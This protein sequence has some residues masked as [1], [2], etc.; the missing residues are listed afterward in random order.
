MRLAPFPQLAPAAPSA[1]RRRGWRSPDLP[2]LRLYGASQEAP[3]AGRFA[4]VLR[5]RWQPSIPHTPVN[6]G[7]VS[8]PGY[9]GSQVTYGLNMVTRMGSWPTADTTSFIRQHGVEDII[10]FHAWH[11]IARQSVGLGPDGYIRAPD[12]T[13]D[14]RKSGRGHSDAH[15]NERRSQERTLNSGDPEEQSRMEA[16]ALAGMR[17]LLK[18]EVERT[19]GHVSYHKTCLLHDIFNPFGQWA[20]HSVAVAM[21]GYAR[22]GNLTTAV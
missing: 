15:Q 13:G 1:Q 5:N 22:A 21:M 17:D 18:G 2:L 9:S 19:D 4:A 3:G 10:P 14:S 20:T 8:T 6:R 12:S 7:S 11:T 16:D